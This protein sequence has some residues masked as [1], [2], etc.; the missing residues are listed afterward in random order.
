MAALLK[1]ILKKMNKSN[2]IIAVLIAIIAAGAYKFIIKGNIVVD[3][4]D[5]RIA[6]GVK[7]GE[8]NFILSEMRA[9]L[10]KIQRLITF[11]SNDDME[12]FTQLAKELKDE[13]RGEEQQALIGKMPIA[14]K[15]MS[16]KIH[17]DFKQ[18]YEDAVEKNDK[19]HSLMRS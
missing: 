2:I 11:L 6:I 10:S 12:G 19:E 1:K 14:F 18:L 5:D 4:S 16:F 3:H 8:R 9:L 7:N 15:Q 17:G 13:S